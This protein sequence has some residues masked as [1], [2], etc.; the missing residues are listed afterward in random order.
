MAS[1]TGATAVIWLSVPPL[2]STAQ[3]LQGFNADNVFETDAIESAETVMGV[4]GFMSA[5]FVYVQVHQTFDIQADSKSTFIF[6]QWW[7]TQ[8]QIRDNYFASAS[9]WLPAIGKKWTMQRGALTSY[10]AIPDVK[11]L[12]NAQRF[13]ITWG[14]VFPAAF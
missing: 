13:R 10:K 1:L 7:A 8:Q 14:K 11:K 3:Q 9:I 2:F 6:D 5:G 12:L 4:D